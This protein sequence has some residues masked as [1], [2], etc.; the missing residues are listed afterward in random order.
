M[1][2]KQDYAIEEVIR[3]YKEE[4]SADALTTDLLPDNV[5]K[6][7]SGSEYTK[8]EKDVVMEVL[9]PE[10][11]A[12]FGLSQGEFK[13]AFRYLTSRMESLNLAVMSREKFDRITSRALENKYDRMYN[14]RAPNEPQAIRYFS[15][16]RLIK[17]L[18]ALS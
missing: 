16:F 3:I 15:Y 9:L 11:N 12:E 5:I 2:V 1:K 10:R 13:L 4:I 8:K 17:S 14:I 18:L 6:C 7:L